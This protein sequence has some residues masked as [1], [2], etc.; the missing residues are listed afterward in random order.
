MVDVSETI[1]NK[2]TTSIYNFMEHISFSAA[3]Y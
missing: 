1:K 3:L 2:L